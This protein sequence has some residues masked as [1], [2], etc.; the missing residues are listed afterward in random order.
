MPAESGRQQQ[1]VD[2]GRGDH[3]IPV[4]GDVVTAG[5]AAGDRRVGE[6]GKS[7]ADLVDGQVDE[8][9]GGPVQVVVRVGGLQ[10]GQIGISEQQLAVRLGPDVLQRYQVGEDRYGAGVQSGFDRH[11][12]F[13]V[14]PDRDVDA[15]GRQERPGPDTGGDDDG[16]CRDPGAV[17]QLDT[18]DSVPVDDQPGHGGA[19]VDSYPGGSGRH[20]E[21]LRGLVGVAVPAAGLPPERRERFQIGPRP[22]L[23]HFGSVDLLGLHPD[24]ALGGQALAQVVD[25]GCPDTDDIA[26][27]PEP[28]VG[29]EVLLGVLEHL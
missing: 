3:G 24:L 8:A 4:R 9:V 17:D 22:H 5:V 2:S 12:L 14:H 20:R 25:V 10:L 1:A 26:G 13:P 29:A 7:S 6:S 23:G 16:A 15:V 21:R 11:D 19:L 27:L 28:D 18:G